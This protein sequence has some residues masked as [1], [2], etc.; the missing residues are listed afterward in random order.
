MVSRVNSSKKGGKNVVRV[1]HF[2]SFCSSGRKGIA[3]GLEGC[4]TRVFVREGRQRF[5]RQL[6]QN[7]FVA[8]Q[9]VCKGAF[10]SSTLAHC[11]KHSGLIG[12]G[13][14]NALYCA[15]VTG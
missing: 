11:P 5:M 12:G 7:P 6:A 3:S 13:H 9:R 15:A 8:R 14:G 1:I 10:G 2:L 4:D